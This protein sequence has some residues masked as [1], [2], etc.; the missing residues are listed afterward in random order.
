MKRHKV[1]PT[2]EGRE[3]GLVQPDTLFGASKKK[4]P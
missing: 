1:V 4:K 3:R 2:E